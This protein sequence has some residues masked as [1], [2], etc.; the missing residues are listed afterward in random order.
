MCCRPI[1]DRMDREAKLIYRCDV[2]GACD[3][4]T[5]FAPRAYEIPGLHVLKREV[6]G[7]V[8]HVVRYK[9]SAL[10]AVIDAIRN[11]GYGLT[12]GIHTRIDSKARYIHSR[13]RVGNTYINRNMIGAVV[14]VQP[15]GGEG[16]SGTGPKAGG[17][18]YLGRFTVP[19]AE[20]LLEDG[21]AAARRAIELDAGKLMNADLPA[22]VTAPASAG[23]V[24]AALARLRAEAADF[25]ARD[26][27]QAGRSAAGSGADPEC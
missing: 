11:T 13:S 5:F 14:G 2:A 6:F 18:N 7:P 16:L 4:G 25:D 22:A 19:V 24:G 17:P 21:L 3:H 23:D 10:D 20:P 9:T 27:G 12:M 8:L 15:F 26:G 1:A